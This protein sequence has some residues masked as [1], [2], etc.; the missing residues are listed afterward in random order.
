[1]F[2]FNGHGCGVQLFLYR[3]VIK[4]CYQVIV[5][6]TLPVLLLH[7]GTCSV[8][9][10]LYIHHN[11]ATICLIHSQNMVHN[12]KMIAVINFIGPANL[13]YLSGISDQSL[14][15]SNLGQHKSFRCNAYEKFQKKKKDFGLIID[16]SC[17]S[18]FDTLGKFVRKK[19]FFSW[20]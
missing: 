19:L 2:T 15:Y 20:I 14:F 16:K 13:W 6:S 3:L 10:E 18:F 1:M 7:F 5:A 8:R 12:H 11:I 17:W 4:I 9:H